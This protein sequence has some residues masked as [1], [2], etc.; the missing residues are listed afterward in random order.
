MPRPESIAEPTPKDLK[1]A[2]GPEEGRK[3]ISHLLVAETEVSFQIGSA[4]G[5]PHP[6]DVRDQRDGAERRQDDEAHPR[7]F[8]RGRPDR[9]DRLLGQF[10]HTG[11]RSR[12]A[13][14]A[15]LHQGFGGDV[16]IRTTR[17]SFPVFSMPCLHQ[18]GR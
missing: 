10:R 16:V 4:C 2:I 18:G 12:L 17:V 13:H 5:E 9:P 7:G 15:W 1:S 14:W 8:L 11:P 6:V 3:H